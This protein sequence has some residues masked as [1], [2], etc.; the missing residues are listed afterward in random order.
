MFSAASSATAPRAPHPPAHVGRVVALLGVSLLLH[1]WVLGGMLRG[2][3]DMPAMN[4]RPARTVTAV[5]LVPP[6]PLPAV[7]RATRPPRIAAA[8]A[9]RPAPPAEVAVPPPDEALLAEATGPAAPPPEQSPPSD[10]QTTAAA[11][12][13]APEPVLPTQQ[14]LAGA[15]LAAELAQTGFDADGLPPQ[16]TYVYRTTGSEYQA[17]S[18][19][20][21]IAWSL[22][23][24]GRY[25][26]RLTTVVLGITA[27][28]LTS[29]GTV[30]RF[31]LA[32]ERYTQ[33]R[34][35][36]AA[37]AAN[38]DWDRQR[39][40]FS[41][42]SFERE[43]REG[44]QDRLSFQFQLMALAQRLPERFRAGATVEFPV[45]GPGGVDIYA[46]RVG[47]EETI[48]TELGTWVARKLERPPGVDG[49]DARIEVWLAPSL[50]W[51]PVK[52]RFTD[53]RGRTTE[54]VLLRI[55]HAS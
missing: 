55:E 9:A 52:L 41:A 4:E 13:V 36:R 8:A 16:A 5:L 49:A 24:D 40:T 45:A 34:I 15:D 22:A 29:S 10:T 19:E 26:A 3:D 18:A 46:F 37:E 12:E 47:D 1:A 32:P 35:R 27:L 44:T 6:A 17:L 21:A 14:L 11:P 54:N 39:V 31:G 2:I 53:R 23:A 25:L 51:L 38:F 7:S 43:L 42:R 48:V 50:Q 30:R 28:E 20:T 33:K